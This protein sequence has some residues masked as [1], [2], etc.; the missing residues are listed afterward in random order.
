[1]AKESGRHDLTNELKVEVARSRDSVAREFR[2]VR[3]ELDIPRKIRRSFQEQ[4]PVWIGAAALVGVLLFVLPLRKK[5]V[6]AAPASADNSKSKLVKAG[7]AL[8][9]LRIAA[10]LL[11]P[12]VLNFVV[13]KM[14]AY[15]NPD[16]PVNKW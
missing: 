16:E 11:K 15:T 3:Y 7:F 14:R 4:T 12:L 9:A 13:N 5:K 8:G 6:C 2:A 10:S 1:M